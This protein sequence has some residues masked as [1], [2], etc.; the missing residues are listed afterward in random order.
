MREI[1]TY[2]LDHVGALHIYS[3]VLSILYENM[4]K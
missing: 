4:N 2:V 3:I 1:M